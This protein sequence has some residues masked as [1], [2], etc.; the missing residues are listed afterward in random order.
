MM[1]GDGVMYSGRAR[2]EHSS[3][4]FRIASRED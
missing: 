2:A 3:A 1:Y 4:L